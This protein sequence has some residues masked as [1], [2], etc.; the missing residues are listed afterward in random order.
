MDVIRA[1]DGGDGARAPGRGGGVRDLHRRG[2][3]PPSG[4]AAVCRL[5][6]RCIQGKMSL[7]GNALDDQTGPD[8]Y[9]ST[10]TLVSAPS[11][12]GCNSR[13]DRRTARRLAGVAPG[14][15]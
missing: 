10:F 15:T 3:A 6:T 14:R 13:K 4:V 11:R 7:S 2:V 8:Y 9:G 12:P 5:K 1:R